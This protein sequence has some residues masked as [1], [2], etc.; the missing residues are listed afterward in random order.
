LSNGA[1][2]LSCSNC[3]GGARVGALGRRSNGADGTLLFN[4]VNK[5]SAG[6]Y[7]LTLYYSNGSTGNRDLD[8]SINGGPVIVFTR[9]ATGSFT[10]FETGQIS[11][12]L[13][14]GENTIKF[15]NPQSAT[16]DIDKIV[17]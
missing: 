14:A 9:D 11:V 16:L 13:N 10:T 17:V 7:T 5:N 15:D 8:I 4:N 2:V 1:Q 6:Q 12:N 3:S